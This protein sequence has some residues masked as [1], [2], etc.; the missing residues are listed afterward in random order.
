MPYVA[1]I[2]AECGVDLGT[3]M[4][5][6]PCG[7]ANM[8]DEEVIV[9]ETGVFICHGCKIQYSNLRAADRYY[10]R[11]YA[12][13]QD[14]TRIIN[15]SLA[16]MKMIFFSTIGISNYNF[17][18]PR[19]LDY[20]GRVYR[21]LNVGKEMPAEICNLIM[22]WLHKNQPLQPEQ[23]KYDIVMG[24][25]MRNIKSHNKYLDR[26][27]INKMEFTTAWVKRESILDGIIG[28]K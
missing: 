3:D 10:R 20:N 14:R 13:L 15:Q 7:V 17:I 8:Q 4:Q 27:D 19:F 23:M 22:Y 24:R 9:S 2:C 12:Q 28:Y 5:I 18:H 16:S 26:T 6:R 1:E 21:M 11:K 25:V